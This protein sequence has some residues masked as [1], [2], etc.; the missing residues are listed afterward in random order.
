M[1]GCVITY[2]ICHRAN[3]ADY[4]NAAYSSCPD[5]FCKKKP[6]RLTGGSARWPKVQ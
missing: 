6:E 3:T 4:N 2:V 5:E 1:Q